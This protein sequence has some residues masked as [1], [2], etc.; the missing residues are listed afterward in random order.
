LRF[1]H[2]V[3]KAE[4]TEARFESL[5]FKVVAIHV[6]LLA[7]RLLGVIG[8]IFDELLG[9]LRLESKQALC[10]WS[11]TRATAS[12]LNAKEIVEEDTHEVVVQKKASWL[13][14]NQKRE[15]GQTIS[16]GTSK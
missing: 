14:F 12:C 15:D 4:S 9:S 6:N 7:I 5:I 13:V 11:G 3:S 2:E 10:I 16:K 1:F 8:Q